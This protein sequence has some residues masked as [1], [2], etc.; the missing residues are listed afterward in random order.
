MAQSKH[1]E[2]AAGR[3]KRRARPVRWQRTA[4]RICRKAAESRR[5]ASAARRQEPPC[6]PGAL[7]LWWARSTGALR[8]RLRRRLALPL[9]R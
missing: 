2:K 7:C 4:T 6:A 8:A 9:G 3:P 5:S 1:A